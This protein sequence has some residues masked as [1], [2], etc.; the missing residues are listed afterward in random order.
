M[1]TTRR[2]ASPRLAWAALAL[3]ICSAGA[4]CAQQGANPEMRAEAQA[5]AQACRPDYQRHCSGVRPGGGRVLACLRG[6][7]QRQLS[8][9]CREALPKAAA[10]QSRAT[11]AGNMPR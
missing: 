3:A 6:Q 9:A 4:A 2:H 11:A 5:L 1:M 10:L 8:P 7:D